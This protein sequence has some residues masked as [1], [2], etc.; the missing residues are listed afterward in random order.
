MNRILMILAAAALIGA[1]AAVHVRAQEQPGGQG[2]GPAVTVKMTDENTYDP[3][4]V[5]IQAGR[6]IEWTNPSDVFHTVT[7]DPEKAN[8][9]SH[10]VLP[11]G[12]E[13]FDS[14]RIDP[15]ETYRRTFDVPGSYK[16]FCIP[17]ERVGMIGT[18]EVK[19]ADGGEGD[20]EAAKGQQKGGGARAQPSQARKGFFSNLITWIGK[21]HPPSINI[22]IGLILAAVVAEGLSMATKRPM[23]DHAGRFCV[24]L[25]AIGAVVSVSLGWCFAGF[26]L[27]DADW[28]MTTHRWV[29]T[30][31]GLWS[32]VVLG[33]S[34]GSRRPGQGS[35]RPWYLAALVIGA[36]LISFNGHFGGLMVYGPEH[37]AW[38]G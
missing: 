34:E 27:T 32:L 31:A 37:Y 2:S 9:P 20:G 19:P 4:D 1:G 38:P 3:K 29:G 5:T 21:F 35:L 12:V 24:W 28:M 26:R 23:F 30:T 6:T 13:P 36:A 16:Y 8:D 14:G 22:P 15:G 17:H 18:I 25:A 33:L 11:E 10:V 7:A